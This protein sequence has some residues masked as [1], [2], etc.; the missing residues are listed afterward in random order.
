MQARYQYGNLTLRKRKKGPDVWQFRW[1]E[2]GKLKSMLIGTVDRYSKQ[3]DA[4]RAVE[5]L[6]IRINAENA[7]QQFHQLTVG[8]LIDR[9]MEEY[10]PKRCRRPTQKLYSSLFENHIRPKW[11][12]EFVR[13]VKTTSVEDWLD[14]YPHSVQI[15]PTFAT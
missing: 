11:G 5:H 12:T 1:M 2:N 9:F 3:S 6:R 4:E 10:T 15:S 7:Q 13:T 14:G 8:A